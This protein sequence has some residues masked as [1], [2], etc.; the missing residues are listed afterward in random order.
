[1]SQL[2]TNRMLVSPRAVWRHM[3]LNLSK[4][5]DIDRLSFL[6]NMCQMGFLFSV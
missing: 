4:T 1:M 3:R 2:V 5:V 6:E